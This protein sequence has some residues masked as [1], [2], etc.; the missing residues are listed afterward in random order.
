MGY[1]PDSSFIPKY[2]YT[3][4]SNGEKYLID[5]CCC[6]VSMGGRH[7]VDLICTDKLGLKQLKNI[8]TTI[9]KKKCE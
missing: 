7:Y 3:E 1:G 8:S 6:T 2:K 9:L 4:I 5:S